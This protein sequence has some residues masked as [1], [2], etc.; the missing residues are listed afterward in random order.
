MS[1]RSLVFITLLSALCIA[2][3]GHESAESAPTSTA[4]AQSRAPSPQTSFV[5]SSSST[6]SAAAADASTSDAN[7]AEPASQSLERLAAAPPELPGGRW[8]A[9]VNYDVVVP[10]QPTDSPAGKVEVLEVFWLGCPHCY[11]LEPYIRDWLKDKPSYVNF[12]RIPVMWGPVHRLHARLFYT[13]EALGRNDLVEKAFDTIHQ[14]NYLIGQNESDTFDKQLEWAKQS[15]I[16]ADAFRKAYNSF[17]VTA[18][19]EHAQ[20]ITDRYHVEGV[21]FVVV[22]GKYSTD[23]GKAG[24]HPELIRLIDDLAAYEHRSTHAG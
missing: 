7:A 8:K 2:A 21:P 14:G 11:A 12:V 10:A 16:D 3:C 15:G 17:G 4:A 24:G 6:A 20:E 1:D 5:A 18:D 13:L 22:A 9:A 19:L 23:V